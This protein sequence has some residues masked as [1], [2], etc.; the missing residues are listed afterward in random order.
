MVMSKVTLS[1]FHALSLEEKE[2]VLNWR[3]DDD[4]RKWM[5]TQAIIPLSDHLN[6]IDSLPSRKDRAYFLVK[7]E[8]EA[9]GVIDFTNITAQSADIGLYAKPMLKG[10]GKVLMH[11]I[12]AYGFYV[13]KVET[14]I[15]EVLKEN[16]SAIRLYKKFDFKETDRR[17][18]IIV[19]ELKNE[20][21]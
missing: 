17:E 18:N 19:M 11:E 20:N 5:F 12:I 14:L 2:M 1:A 21:R 13:L 3:N 15:S 9:I 4:V 6:Y 10:M 16:E 7:N 8:N